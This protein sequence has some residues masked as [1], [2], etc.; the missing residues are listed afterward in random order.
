MYNEI[1]KIKV[2]NRISNSEIQEIFG[3]RNMGGLRYSKENRLLI[4]INNGDVEFFPDQHMLVDDK[5]VI[6]YFGEGNYGNQKITR[7][8][9]RLY[10][11]NI[12]GT[13]L[14]YFVKNKSDNLYTY[15]GRVELINKTA[16]S[17]CFYNDDGRL[18]AKT[19]DDDIPTLLEKVTH[20]EAFKAIRGPYRAHYYEKF[21]EWYSYLDLAGNSRSVIIFPLRELER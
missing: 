9:K 16:M 19:G 20:A 12:E 15:N 13:P 18:I 5:R 14:H 4:V 2:G 7:G 3:G 1:N 8:N 21:N 11:S 10:N 6:F 17:K